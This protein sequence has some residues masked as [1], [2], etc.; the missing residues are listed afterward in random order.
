MARNLKTGWV[1]AA[2]S[3][4][5]IDGREIKKEWL[6]DIAKFYSEK[7]FCAK[8][9]PDHERLFN[10][11]GK[12]L[13]AKV[14]PATDPLLQGEIHLMVILAPSDDLV[15]ANQRGRLVHT[16]IEVLKNFANKGIF[17]LGGIA[18]TDQPASL[19]TTELQFSADSESDRFY[20]SGSP[21]DLSSAK[22]E[23]EKSF[24]SF[25]RK[26]SPEPEQDTPMTA[27]QF[28]AL[29]A[30]QQQT[31][32]AIATLGEQFKTQQPAPAPTPAP[33]PAPIVPPAPEPSAD[34]VSKKSFDELNEKFTKLNDAF[35]A[36]KANAVPGTAP[37]GD[38]A[39]AETGVIC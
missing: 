13:A 17:Y 7:L 27:E 8:I 21:V 12:V 2:T 15:Y 34:F 14:E 37:A 9:W 22:E 39:S 25:L 28:Q 16:S 6:E 4:S 36:A 11:Q 1:I 32:A 29:L 33:V 23:Q 19:G 20:I 3:G 30:A 24:F 35:E 26:P 31:A 10:S 5:T 18:V 38:D